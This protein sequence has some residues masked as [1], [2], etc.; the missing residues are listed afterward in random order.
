MY[1]G[2]LQI[3]WQYPQTLLT[4]SAQN[5]RSLKA[6]YCVVI[7]IIFSISKQQSKLF[8]DVCGKEIYV[9]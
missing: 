4:F 6:N 3:S 9:K 2:K 7:E 5:R 8:L 1:V